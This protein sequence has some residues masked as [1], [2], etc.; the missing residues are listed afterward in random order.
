MERLWIVLA[1][2]VAL[3]VFARM[4]AR[5]RAK[6]RRI[7]PAAG[8][9]IQGSYV[10]GWLHPRMS[11]ACL[12]DCGVQFGK[13]FRR[14]EGPTLPHDDACGCTVVPFSFT[15]NEVFNGAL[16]N[17]ST[18][19]ASIEGM[20]GAE[21][22]HLADR[23][24]AVESQPL[25]ADAEGYAA[26]VGVDGFPA[27]LHEPVRAF[28]AERH[29]FLIQGATGGAAPQGTATPDEPLEPTEI[30]TSEPT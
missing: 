7:A 8:P 17:A 19:R 5:R 11:A 16:R 22:M 13:G 26:A 30:E 3:F 28:L 6:P 15:S 29:A 25:P 27:A 9:R 23:L 18:A 20:D 14:K 24:R 10:S 2:L 4:R 1:A 12:Y 21:A